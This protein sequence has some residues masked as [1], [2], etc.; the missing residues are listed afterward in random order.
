MPGARP[1]GG[2]SRSGGQS[3]RHRTIG[4]GPTK[5][6]WV[7]GGVATRIKI[8]LPKTVIR[9]LNRTPPR[10]TLRAKVFVHSMDLAGRPSTVKLA[11]VLRGRNGS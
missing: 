8:P 2:S 3:H 6:R 1:A 7:A 4:L 11:V 5:Y 9:R 10:E